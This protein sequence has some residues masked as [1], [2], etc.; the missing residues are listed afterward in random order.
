MSFRSRLFIISMV[1]LIVS[2]CSVLVFF[3]LSNLKDKPITI[4]VEPIELELGEEKHLFYTVSPLSAIVS[5]E[6]AN[7][8]IASVNNGEI[9]ALNAGSTNL[10]TTATY[11]GKSKK[12]VSSII[13]HAPVV[14]EPS[15]SFV[16]KDI[17]GGCY[18][19]NKITTNAQYVMFSI[20]IFK[21]SD[22]LSPILLLESSEG[23]KITK[24]F[25]Y[26]TLEINQSGYIKL[27]DSNDAF[28]FIIFVEKIEKV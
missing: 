16:I 6:I 4:N 5:F 8:S 7:P 9:K 20:E 11:K 22:K 1:C 14:I 23:I 25:Y 12:C 19:E 10:T 27:K 17:N 21:G 26:L 24:Q 28:E 18:S 15:Y 2:I 3:A 13:V